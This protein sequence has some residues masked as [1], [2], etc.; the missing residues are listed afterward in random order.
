MAVLAVFACLSVAS[1][2]EE[3]PPFMLS[4]SVRSIQQVGSRFIV[5]HD[6]GSKTTWYPVGSSAWSNG[7]G[8]QW[9]RTS[10][11]W[12]ERSTPRAWERTSRG[13]RMFPAREESTILVNPARIRVGTNSFTRTANG[14]KR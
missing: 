3:V 13:W 7:A 12:K 4:E 10:T 5:M 2:G 11:G 14:I 9:E 6:D 1:R 8:E